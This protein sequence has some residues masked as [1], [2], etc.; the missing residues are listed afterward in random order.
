MNRQ[1]WPI[2]KKKKKKK[3]VFWNSKSVKPNRLVQTKPCLVVCF[4]LHEFPSLPSKTLL[5]KKSKKHRKYKFL[6]T[7]H[8]IRLRLF[9]RKTFSTVK[10]LQMQMIYGKMFV[11]PMFVCTLGKCSRKYSTL[12]V[13]SNVKQT[14]PCHPP[15]PTPLPTTI[16]PANPPPTT[17]PTTTATHETPTTTATHNPATH[18]CHPPQPTPLPTTINKKTTPPTTTATQS[19][20][21][22]QPPQPTQTNPQPPQPTPATH[23]NPPRYP[24][25][26]TKKTHHQ[27][28]NPQP[29]QPTTTQQITA[30]H[31]PRPTANNQSP[32]GNKTPNKNPLPARES[33]I[34]EGVRLCEIDEGGWGWAVRDRRARVREWYCA[35]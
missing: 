15:Q 32:T 25:Q 26:S 16:N 28:R 29:P 6:P 13:W 35:I 23:R 30:T 33:E 22:P 34:D 21:N 10:C 19:Q 9:R 27:P 8:N 2:W 17:K 4:Q 3:T 14:H 18:L 12:C 24:P 5:P 7:W 1:V 31:N 11:F 20:T